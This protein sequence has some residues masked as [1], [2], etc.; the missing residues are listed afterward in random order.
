MRKRNNDVED[1]GLSSGT[2]ESMT[3]FV[4]DCMT[5]R[6]LPASTRYLTVIVLGIT[7]SGGEVGETAR[8]GAAVGAGDT[9]R[10]RSS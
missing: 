4:L 10:L 1:K 2:T 5:F 8:L 3:E 7:P 6:V 9:E